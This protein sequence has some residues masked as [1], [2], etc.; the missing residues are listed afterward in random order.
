V[1]RET[2]IGKQRVRPARQLFHL[3]PYALQIFFLHL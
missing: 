3:N 2:G 1:R